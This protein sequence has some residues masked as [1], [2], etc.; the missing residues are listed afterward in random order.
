M[1]D[2]ILSF[3]AA[4]TKPRHLAAIRRDAIYVWFNMLIW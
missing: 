3:N 2:V 1:I 4:N